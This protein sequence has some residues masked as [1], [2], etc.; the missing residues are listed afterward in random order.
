MLAH[1]SHLLQPL[2]IGCFGP[3]KRSYSKEIKNLMQMYISYIIKIEFFT[4]FKN[5]FIASFDKIN[6]REGFQGTSLILFDL[7]T[8]ISKLDVTPRTLISIS[9]PTATI[10]P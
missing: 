2:D 1:S 5:A 8:V 9:P 10:K 6:I 4:A 3:L 7:E